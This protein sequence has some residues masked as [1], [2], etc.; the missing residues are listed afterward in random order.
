MGKK[1]STRSAMQC[2]ISDMKKTFQKNETTC[3]SLL[4]KTAKS[5]PFNF[6]KEDIL[7]LS[8]PNKIIGY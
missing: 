1:I 8:I 5:L 3:L 6:M 4:K 7:T 2:A